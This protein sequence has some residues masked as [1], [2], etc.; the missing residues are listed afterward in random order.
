MRTRAPA[1]P[2]PTALLAVVLGVGLPAQAQD[3]AAGTPGGWHFAVTPYIWFASLNGDVATISGLPP[4]SVDADFDDIIENADL[5][6]MVAAEARRGG[7]G[8]ITDLNYLSLSTDGDTPGPLFAGAQVEEQ[9]FFANVGGFYRGVAGDRLNVDVLAGARIWY[10]NTEIDL[11]AGLRPARSVQDDNAWADTRLLACAR[12]L[13]SAG[14]FSSPVRPTSVASA[15][16]RTS[17][18]SYWAQSDTSSTTGCRP[19]PATAISRSTTRT[20]ASSGMW[21]SAGQSSA[22][23]SAFESRTT[24]C[25]A[26]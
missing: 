15:W 25:S 20:T 19:A 21:S 4:V 9:T 1:F 8:I 22:Q 3:T 11:R 24:G 10:V 7:F 13:S 18:G 2:L 26:P 17:H 5:A 6:F 12:P 23:P 14:A 16:H